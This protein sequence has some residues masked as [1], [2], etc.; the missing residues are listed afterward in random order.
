MYFCYDYLTQIFVVKLSL[1]SELIFDLESK[2]NSIVVVVTIFVC[3][4]LFNSHIASAFSIFILGH[5]EGFQLGVLMGE[6]YIG[7][8]AS[9]ESRVF[10]CKIIKIGSLQESRHEFNLD[11][12]PAD[13]VLF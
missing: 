6:K 7:I 1:I 10:L 3:H 13:Q 11:I 8:F 4:S 2:T 12:Q 5:D 9:L